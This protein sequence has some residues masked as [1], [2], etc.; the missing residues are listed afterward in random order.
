M[1]N[2]GRFGPKFG[3]VINTPITIIYVRKALGFCIIVEIYI[4]IVWI[5]AVFYLKY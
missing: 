2:F 3:E 1:Q 5:L 4:A